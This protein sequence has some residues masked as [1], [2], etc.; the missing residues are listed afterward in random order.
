MPV[1][2]PTLERFAPQQPQSVGRIDYKPMDATQ[3]QAMQSNAVEKLGTTAI[4]VYEKYE[5]QAGDTESEKAATELHRHLE[6]KLEGPGGAKHWK[7]DP[8]EAYKKYDDEEKT[9]YEEITNRYKDSSDTTRRLVE[10]KLASVRLK[11]DDRR[12]TAFGSQTSIY[13]AGVAKDAIDVSIED[14]VHDTAHLDVTDPHTTIPLDRSIS[15]I[16]D[17]HYALGEKQG[18]VVNGVASPSVKLDIARSVSKGIYGAIDNLNAAGDVD[19]AKFLLEKYKDKLDVKSRANAE[20]KT[21]KAYDEQKADQEFAKVR[22]LEKDKAFAALDKIKDDNIREKAI[23]NLDTY[24]RHAENMQKREQ[25]DNFERSAKIVFDKERTGDPFLTVNDMESD[26]RIKKYLDK[27]APNQV[28]HLRKMIDVPNESDEDAKTEALDLIAT[29]QLTNIKAADLP[30]ITADLNDHDRNLFT[31]EWIKANTDTEPEVRSRTKFMLPQLTK[32]LESIGYIKKNRE[33]KYSKEDEKRN[34]DARTEL[35]IETNAMPKGM[36]I[37]DQEQWVK[38]KA[39]KL[40]SS[41]TRQSFFDKI[42][43]F[44]SGNPNKPV[45]QADPKVIVP[46]ASVPTATPVPKSNGPQ[47]STVDLFKLYMKENGGKKPDARQLEAFRKEKS[48]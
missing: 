21:K 3:G 6:Q 44:F 13:E 1:Q 16:I 8:T 47:L 5:K 25:D 34:N 22:G 4:G 20:E 48:K 15:K 28:E 38:D 37:S 27:M 29:N 11:F 43:S 32:Q 39:M 46:K 42:S 36:S 9:K 30:G 10:E 12:T 26:P 40:K 14:M 7:G 31:N 35:I 23:A 17:Q 2:V 24:H 41:D 19:G 45:E 18:T 33:G